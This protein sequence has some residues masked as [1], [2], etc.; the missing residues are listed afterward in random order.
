MTTT[1][2]WFRRD[3]RLADNPALAAA[4]AGGDVV[5]LFVIDPAFIRAGAPRLAFLAEC[6]A[7]LHEATRGALVIRRGNPVDVVPA[8]ADRGGG[9]DGEHRRRLRPVRP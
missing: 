3:L 8:V 2:M 7:E 9:L 5:P 4:A 6:L 1:V